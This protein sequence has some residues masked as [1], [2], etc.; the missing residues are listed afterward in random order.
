MPHPEI[1]PPAQRRTP[2]TLSARRVRIL[3]RMDQ[4]L[5]HIEAGFLPLFQRLK[6]YLEMMERANYPHP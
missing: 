2:P 3:N 6:E 5:A 1:T 4:R